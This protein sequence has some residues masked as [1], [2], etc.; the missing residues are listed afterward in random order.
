MIP[1]LPET[2][3]LT[4]LQKEASNTRYRNSWVY[5]TGYNTRRPDSYQV[6]T[7]GSHTVTINATTPKLY[8]LIAETDKAQ[9]EKPR[10]VNHKQAPLH[11]FVEDV[12]TGS[13]KE[14]IICD[15]EVNGKHPEFDRIVVDYKTIFHDCLC[16]KAWL[17]A[18]YKDIIP[19]P[20]IEISIDGKSL[21]VNGNYKKGLIKE[22]IKVN[23]GV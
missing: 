16:G 10:K 8:E 4:R 21:S 19:E 7:I 22:F 12:R 5:G 17:E 23:K 15:Y 6:M 9:N 3:E 14:H 1:L 13:H 2:C 20:T 18:H 11:G